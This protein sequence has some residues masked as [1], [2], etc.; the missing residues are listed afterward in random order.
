MAGRERRHP[1]KAYL[2]SRQVGFP[3]PT[4]NG[5]P[6]TQPTADVPTSPTGPPEQGPTG[7]AGC[8]GCLQ[9]QRAHAAGVSPNC[10]NP[11]D[12][13]GLQRPVPARGIC[14]RTSPFPKSLVRSPLCQCRGPWNSWVSSLSGPRY[15]GG[16]CGISTHCFP[17]VHQSWPSLN[18]DS[19]G[20]VP[21]GCQSIP[22]A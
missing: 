1:S 15:V 8:P 16:D 4:N 14:R 12:A 11:A 17:N 3:Q 22:T 5:P 20:P 7:Q 18:G 6:P 10:R 9:D 13:W 2:R 19:R 21:K